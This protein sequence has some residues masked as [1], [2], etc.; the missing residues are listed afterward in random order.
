MG[1]YMHH[2]QRILRPEVILSVAAV[3]FIVAAAFPS[4]V[5]EA[6]DIH[7]HDTYYVISLPH[8]YTLAAML[9][10]LFAIIYFL[11]RKFRQWVFLQYFHLISLAMVP[12]LP[13]LFSMTFQMKHYPL[14]PE[15]AFDPYNTANMMTMF[16][17]M[18]FL[19]GQL[20][21]LINLAAGF[22]RGKKSPAGV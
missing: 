1:K 20:A 8:V 11:T 15:D 6:I 13:V 18:I 9:F 17:L 2:F 16:V 5:S 7:L 21:F 12:L 3:G 14:Q 10:A 19:L 4:G 22:I